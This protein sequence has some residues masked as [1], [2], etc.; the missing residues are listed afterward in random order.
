MAAPPSFHRDIS[1]TLQ[2]WFQVW[3]ARNLPRRLRFYSWSFTQVNSL[4]A[5]T[6]GRDISHALQFW[7]SVVERKR[8]FERLLP[9]S[10]SVARTASPIPGTER[11]F[12]GEETSYGFRAENCERRRRDWQS[13][14]AIAASEGAGIGKI[15][16]RC[17]LRHDF[18]GKRSR[19]T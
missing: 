11:K 6:C 7:K 3:R 4:R 18:I 12:S 5:Q 19:T 2:F 10:E 16:K 8:C 17:F 1:R 14:S 15:G 13:R 9:S